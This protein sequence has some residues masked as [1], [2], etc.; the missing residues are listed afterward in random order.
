MSKKTDLST[1]ELWAKLFEAPTVEDY[2]NQ[3][4]HSQSLAVFSDYITGLCREK[5]EKPEQI[6]KRSDIE[7][8]FGHR[9]FS[10][11]RNPSRDTVIQLAF[12]FELNADET[13]QLLKAAR[14]S[15]LHPRVKRDAVIAFCL[16]NQK[17]LI[18]AQQLLYENNLPIL[19]G[20][21]IGKQ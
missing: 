12:G 5:G 15:A 9:L 3:S 14:L 21:H 13:Q 2:F 10:G 8:S 1:Q 16:H 11:S 18:T 6:L 7:P 19:G 4:K 20:K 17:P